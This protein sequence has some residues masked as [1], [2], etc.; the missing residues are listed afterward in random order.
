MGARNLLRNILGPNV[1]LEKV[2][3]PIFK[4]GIGEPLNAALRMFEDEDHLAQAAFAEGWE[5]LYVYEMRGW[6]RGPYF[7]RGSVSPGPWL[8]EHHGRCSCLWHHRR[9]MW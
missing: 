1:E 5:K 2:E 4:A 6:L 7:I 8:C 9:R 3:A